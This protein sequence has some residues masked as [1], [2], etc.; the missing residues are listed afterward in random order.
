[1]Y[2]AKYITS[3]LDMT[4]YLRKDSVLVDMSIRE[5]QL[6]SY[7]DVVRGGFSETDSDD[8]PGERVAP[9]QAVSLGSWERFEVC[10]CAFVCLYWTELNWV[11][12]SVHFV[13]FAAEIMDSQA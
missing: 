6:V 3:A 12:F 10:A 9:T 5:G 11:Q 2:C 13:C 7:C 4:L 8:T 1:M